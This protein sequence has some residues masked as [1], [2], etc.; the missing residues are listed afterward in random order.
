M[1][2]ATESTSSSPGAARQL[3]LRL[4][5]P[6]A[7]DSWAIVEV[8][9]ELPEYVQQR[10]RIIQQLLAARGTKTYAQVQGQAAR[11]LGISVRSLRRLVSRPAINDCDPPTGCATRLSR[12]G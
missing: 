5:T 6:E 3:V 12:E 11:S 9:G 2:Q 10:M 1:D 8:G 4:P 7:D